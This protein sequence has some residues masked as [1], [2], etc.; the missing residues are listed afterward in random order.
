[1]DIEAE[2]TLRGV[3]RKQLSKSAEQPWK[4]PTS[5]G[6]RILVLNKPYAKLIG[7]AKWADRDLDKPRPPSLLSGLMITSSTSK[8]FHIL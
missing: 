2:H 4:R 7:S 6:Y 5:L 1:M 8:L 3:S